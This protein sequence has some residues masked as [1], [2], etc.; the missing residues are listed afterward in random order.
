MKH[1]PALLDPQR[2]RT[3]PPTESANTPPANPVEKANPDQPAHTREVSY[4]CSDQFLPILR[5]LKASVLVSTY[6]AGKV[7][8][9][10]PGS[11]NEDKLSLSFT[12]FDQPMGRPP[13][14]AV[15]RILDM[16]TNANWPAN[17]RPRV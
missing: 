13:K 11:A 8:V 5:H 12:N 16:P 6:Q 7:A 9:I 2:H 10:A 15:S 14:T 4:R 17:E 3:A 1:A